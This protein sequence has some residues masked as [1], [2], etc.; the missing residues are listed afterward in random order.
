MNSTNS[1]LL[2]RYN[3]ENGKAKLPKSCLAFSMLLLIQGELL[4]D[5]CDGVQDFLAGSVEVTGGQGDAV[6]NALHL[7]HAQATGG[8]GGGADADTGGVG[9]LLRIVGNGV[10]VDGDVYLVQT[11]LHLLAR[12][13]HGAEIHQNEVV[14]G[15]ARD[16]IKAL[17]LQ[18][19]G[20]SLAVENDLM[21]V[22][23]EL[24]LES[25]AEANCLSSNGVHKRTA[26][27]TG[28]YSLVYLLCKL[29]VVGKYHTAA[30]TAESFVRG[31]GM[32]VFL[33]GKARKWAVSG[34]SF[35]L[36]SWR[37]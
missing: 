2:N 24:G 32:L 4:A 16:Q 9:R 19:L 30:R 20:Q 27:N 29:L 5:I 17:G 13:A 22:S 36:W 14:V 25:L 6:G 31:G 35:L 15:A 12:D 7:L 11:L 34:Q 23:L 21:L 3:R 33:E 18:R 8:G 1:N 37:S 28:E 26:L 10:L